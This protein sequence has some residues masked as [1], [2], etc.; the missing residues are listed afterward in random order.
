MTAEQIGRLEGVST[1][2][3]RTRY[4]S[5]REAICRG[6]VHVVDSVKLYEVSLLDALMAFEEEIEHGRKVQKEAHRKAALRVAS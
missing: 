6:R 1:W 5:Q 3:G 2:M 4:H